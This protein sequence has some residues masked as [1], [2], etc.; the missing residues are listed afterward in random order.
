MRVNI[1]IS[2]DKII[3]RDFAQNDIADIVACFAKNNWKKSKKVLHNMKIKHAISNSNAKL[4][5]TKSLITISSRKNYYVTFFYYLE[6]VRKSLSKLVD[7]LYLQQ[8][9][10]LTI[11]KTNN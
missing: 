1:M 2:E 9:L 3:I 10:Y 4:T 6:N 11:Q 8:E 7:I 5:T